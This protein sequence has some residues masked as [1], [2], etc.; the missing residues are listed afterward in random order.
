[1]VKKFG[2]SIS[3]LIATCTLTI[4][5][6]HYQMLKKFQ[7]LETMERATLEMYGPSFVKVIFGNEQSRSCLNMLQR[8]SSWGPPDIPLEDL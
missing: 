4:L 5:D 2:L 8:A 1:M 6:L 7:P 3:Q